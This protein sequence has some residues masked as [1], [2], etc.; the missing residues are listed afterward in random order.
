MQ[1]AQRDNA[2]G[3]RFRPQFHVRVIAPGLPEQARTLVLNRAGAIVEWVPCPGCSGPEGTTLPAACPLAPHLEATSG[4]TSCPI[5]VDT[6][7]GAVEL[8]G[9]VRQ[10]QRRDG[11]ETVWI[12][13]QPQEKEAM[14]GLEEALRMH[15]FA[16]NLVLYEPD[17]PEADRMRS[18]WEGIGVAPER[19]DSWFAVMRKL[20]HGD[21]LGVVADLD[22]FGSLDMGFSLAKSIYPSTRVIAFGSPASVEAARSSPVAADVDSFLVKPVGKEAFLA[23]LRRSAAWTGW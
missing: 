17:S 10:V 18:L 2:K 16:S 13:F 19:E 23:A 14:R 22:A 1:S 9:T 3:L 21:S 8:P 7:G 5:T 15:L 11:H 20:R 4:H 12:A 6:P